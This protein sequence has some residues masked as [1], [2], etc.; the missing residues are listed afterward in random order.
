VI[1]VEIDE[2]QHRAST[3]KGQLSEDE[4]IEKIRV[5]MKGKKVVVIRFN[6]DQ[7]KG[8]NSALID[9]KTKKFADKETKRLDELIKKIKV[10][11]K[12]EISSDF[13]ECRMYYN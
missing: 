2:F 4:R 10:Y 12:K 8:H 6:P 3:Y 5:G 11:M 1:I 7:Y 13:E 9:T